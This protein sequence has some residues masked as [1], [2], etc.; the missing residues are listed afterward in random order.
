MRE[1]KGE[2]PRHLTQRHPKYPAS[3]LKEVALQQ[4]WQQTKEMALQHLIPM[5]E[6]ALQ[7]QSAEAVKEV[8]LQHPPRRAKEM[9]LQRPLPAKEMALQRQP[10]GFCFF[11]FRLRLCLESPSP[12]NR[13]TLFRKE[14]A[15]RPQNLYR[16]EMALQPCRKEM[17]LQPGWQPRQG[18]TTF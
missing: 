1:P 3:A 8:A 16:K 7:H 4:R 17:A 15:L 11:L 5:K 14:M 18:S 12:L 10:W 2:K 13:P 6:M 9:A